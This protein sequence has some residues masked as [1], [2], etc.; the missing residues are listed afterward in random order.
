MSKENTNEAQAAPTDQDKLIHRLRL[1]CAGHLGVLA[2]ANLVMSFIKE[3]LALP[4]SEIFAELVRSIEI[5][6]HGYLPP[7]NGLRWPCDETT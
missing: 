5:Y 4:D 6:L 7:V 1:E 3:G 2:M